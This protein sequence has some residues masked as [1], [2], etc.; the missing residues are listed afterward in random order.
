MQEKTNVHLGD[1]VRQNMLEGVNI[2]GNAVK[3]T[4]GPNGRHVIIQ[5]HTGQVMTKDGVTVAKNINLVNPERDLGAQLV[6]QAAQKT[7]AIAGDGT[8]SST[9]L[10]QFLATNGSKLVKSDTSAVEFKKGMEHAFSKVEEFLSKNKVD[11][12]EDFEKVKQVAT[13][14]ANN[15]EELGAFIAE[16]FEKVGTTG[17]V[18]VEDSKDFTTSVIVKEGMNYDQGFV[19]PYFVTDTA[20]MIAEYSNPY[21]LL[22]DGKIEN[23][24]FLMPL[25]DKVADSDRPLLIIAEE[26]DAQTMSALVVNKVRMGFPV[27]ATKSPGYGKFQK[28]TLEDIAVLTGGKLIT[29]SLGN[30]LEAVNLTDLGTCDKIKVDKGSTYI[31][32]GHGATKDVDE[33]VSNLKKQTSELSGWLKEKVDERIAK[34]TSGVAIIKVGAV[35]DSEMQDKK[36]RLEDALHAVKAALKSGVVAGG[37]ASYLHAR[38][39]LTSLINKVGEGDLS[40]FDL[41]IQNVYQALEIPFDTLCQNGGLSNEKPKTTSNQQGFNFKTNKVENLIETGVV[42]PYLVAV[43]ALRNAV[44]VAGMILTTNCA[45]T[46]AEDIKHEDFGNFDSSMITP[47]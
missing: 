11:I 29:S 8:T 42:D 18:T 17:V 3:S 5:R 27:V 44:S 30:S 33:R 21:I 1:S 39:E 28:E 35:T 20:K 25:L 7:N 47:G 37:G 43:E 15:D 4:L 46:F 9:V 6:K 12:K 45:I 36:Y 40:D 13:I 14:S 41:G 24:K 26:F 34:M 22:H 23:I 38:K 2:L 31:I 10:A 16:A 32:N 19:S